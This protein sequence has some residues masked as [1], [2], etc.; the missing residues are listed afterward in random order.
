MR[1]RWIVYGGAVALGLLVIRL[2]DRPDKRVPAPPAR[3]VA[4]PTGMSI[5]VQTPELALELLG[6]RGQRETARELF[7]PL[8]REA[9]RHEPS[10]P[11]PPPAPQAPPLPLTYLGKLV[12]GERVAVFLSQG[13]RNWVVR[14]GDTIDGVYRVEA[15]G[16]R[17]MTLTYLALD[18]QQQLAIGAAPSQVQSVEDSPVT[19]AL[20]VAIAPGVPP[21][22][23]Q[24]PL[25]FAAPSR[26]ATGGELIVRV[27]LPPGR[28]ASSARV[29]LAYDP[30]VLAAVG[31][32]AGDSGRVQLEL[33]GGASPPA[34]VRFK[35]IAQSST[36]TQI[37]IQNA[38]ATD[39]QGARVA[40][41][42]PGAHDVAIVQVPKTN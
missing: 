32:A 1:P 6:Q 12:D 10:P 7:N 4:Q 21:P 26:V 40:L 11:P 19:E 39:A 35:V 13:D 31:L 17:T 27:G 22:P 14:A 9:P 30:K 5:P 42:A 2:S 34:Q 15:V 36:S 37:G 28:G 18:V 23:G 38:T 16:D 8:V 25:L 20:P 3:V 33:A 24:V 41:A 29:E